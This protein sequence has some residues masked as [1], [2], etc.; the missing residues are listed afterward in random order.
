MP[1]RHPSETKMHATEL[2][3]RSV[4]LCCAVA[5]II[6]CS[7]SAIAEAQDRLLQETVEFTG[8]ITFFEHKVPGLVIGAVRNGERVIS[9]FGTTSTGSNA[10]PDGKTIFRIGSV[11]KA[12]TGAILASTAAEGTVALTDRLEKYLGW[13]VKVPTR[14][15]KAVRLI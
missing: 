2:H 14:E 13:D 12:F 15:G 8:A 7:F 5:I 10:V 4:V 6:A 3:P 1:C 11:T 9:G